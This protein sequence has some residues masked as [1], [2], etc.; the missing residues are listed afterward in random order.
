M[1]IQGVHDDEHRKKQQIEKEIKNSRD[2]SKRKKEIFDRRTIQ[3]VPTP[4]PIK[5]SLLA[6]WLQ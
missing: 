4:R 5:K 6:Q 1:R 2:Y 3:R